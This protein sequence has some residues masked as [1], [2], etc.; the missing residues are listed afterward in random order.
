MGDTS[1]RTA[2]VTDQM[3]PAEAWDAI[4][5][6]TRQ[7]ALTIDAVRT[8]VQSL[9]VSPPAPPSADTAHTRIAGAADLAAPTESAVPA[10]RNTIAGVESH[11]F[12]WDE[13]CRLTV[14]RGSN[15]YAGTLSGTDAHVKVVSD[16]SA[17]VGESTAATRENKHMCA[18]GF[19]MLVRDAP[20]D[21]IVPI[22]SEIVAK[23]VRLRDTGVPIDLKT[24]VLDCARNEPFNALMLCGGPVRLGDLKRAMGPFMEIVPGAIMLTEG[25]GLLSGPTIQTHVHVGTLYEVGTI[26]SSDLN[27]LALGR[28]MAAYDQM[29]A[30]LTGKV[31]SASD[32]PDAVQFGAQC[33]SFAGSLMLDL[34][35]VPFAAGVSGGRLCKVDAITARTGVS[36][37][38]TVLACAFERVHVPSSARGMLPEHS[39]RIFWSPVPITRIADHVADSLRRQTT[40]SSGDADSVDGEALVAPSAMAGA[41]VAAHDCHDGLG[42]SERRS[43]L[44][45]VRTCGDPHD[46]YYAVLGGIYGL[47]HKTVRDRRLL[48]ARR[49]ESPAKTDWFYLILDRLTKCGFSLD[50]HA[51]EAIAYVADQL[52]GEWTARGLL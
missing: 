23:W 47:A 32:L 14:T 45:S 51:Q 48:M 39:V 34:I 38:E 42:I 4:S 49:R 35:F 11:K 28:N 15:A 43:L 13:G 36:I 20:D 10:V 29:V 31:L 50:T 33:M 5:Q 52:F 8:T 37:D 2:T 40:N 3:T 22:G 9:H 30:T 25:G 26:A 46:F 12:P 21:A 6:M 18:S 41:H 1:N 19:Y 16:A 27:P 7:L 44:R 17:P 24:E